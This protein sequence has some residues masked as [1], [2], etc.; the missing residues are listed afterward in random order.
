MKKLTWGGGGG[1]FKLT[2]FK[3]LVISKIL[4]LTREGDPISYLL[5][6]AIGIPVILIKEVEVL[7]IFDCNYL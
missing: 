2:I 6:L 4:C 1:G 3:A 7:N 5:A